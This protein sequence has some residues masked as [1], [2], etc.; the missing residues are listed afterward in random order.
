[1]NKFAVQRRCS[2][3]GV[4]LPQSKNRDELIAKGLGIR[5]GDGSVI[6]HCGKHSPVDILASIEG[7]PKFSNANSNKED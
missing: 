1:M 5:K 2:V 6:W 3:C 7:V 4:L